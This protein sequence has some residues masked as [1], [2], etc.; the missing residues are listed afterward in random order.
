MII[1]ALSLLKT[2][3]T[4]K[5]LLY[6]MLP[7]GSLPEMPCPKYLHHLQSDALICV[8]NYVSSSKQGPCLLQEACGQ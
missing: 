1:V 7:L 3:E 8:N 5:G 6:S 2:S 4:M